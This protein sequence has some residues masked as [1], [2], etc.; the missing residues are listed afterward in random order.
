MITG[1]FKKSSGAFSNLEAV[2]V[3]MI[4]LA[5]SFVLVPAYSYW[6]GW[7]QPTKS[8]IEINMRP[9]KHPGTSFVPPNLREADEPQKNAKNTNE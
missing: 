4:T 5:L 6:M 7:M 2:V 1:S 3:I 8:D 9:I